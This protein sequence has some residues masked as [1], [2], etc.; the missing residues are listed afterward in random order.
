MHLENKNEKHKYLE[1]KLLQI[2]VVYED[3]ENLGIK[4]IYELF[5]SALW[6]MQLTSEK[7]C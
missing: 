3:I 1:R 7:F 2:N 5:V 6:M 4:L